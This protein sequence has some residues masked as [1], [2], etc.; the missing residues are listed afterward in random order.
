[1]PHCTTQATPMLVVTS[2]MCYIPTND[3]VTEQRYSRSYHL[4]APY[5]LRTDK[6]GRSFALLL[7]AVRAHKPYLAT[8]DRPLSAVLWSLETTLRA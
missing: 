2:H 4:Q 1:L 6:H 3:V 7:I 8:C 5:C